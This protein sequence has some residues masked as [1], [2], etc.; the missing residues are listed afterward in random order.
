MQDCLFCKITKGEVASETLYE[1]EIV[2]VFL[3]INP[4]TN[5]DCMIVPKKHV[6]TIEDL[7]DELIL[8]MHKIALKM[9]ALLTEKLNCAG[10]TIAINNG[11]G[12]DIKHFH[13]HLTPRYQDD[14]LT[15][16]F[17]TQ[18]LLPITEVKKQI[19]S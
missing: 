13:M 9:K 5:G 7:D 16:S 15:L 12:Q 6:V 3:D 8:H 14:E 18:N 17:N 2:K 10:L 19:L 11:Y 1:D 4:S